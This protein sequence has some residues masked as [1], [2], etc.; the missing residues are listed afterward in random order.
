MNERLTVKARRI[1]ACIVIKL[2]EK[3]NA[4]QNI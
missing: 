2:T 3:P 1:Q 4:L